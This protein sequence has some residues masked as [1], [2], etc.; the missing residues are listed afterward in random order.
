[1]PEELK[2]VGNAAV[3]PAPVVADAGIGVTLTGL[4]IC[5]PPLKNVTVPVAPTALL[6]PEE[7]VAVKVTLVPVVTVDGLAASAVAV[8]AL[9]TIT[10]STTPVATA[11]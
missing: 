1:M 4:P 10:V 8:A 11:L 7:I 6:L 3:P 2:D 9:D 5:V